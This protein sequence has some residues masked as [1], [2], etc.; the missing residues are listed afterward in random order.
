MEF[1]K[2]R[3]VPDLGSTSPISPIFDARYILA[4]YELARASEALNKRGQAIDYYRRFL[5]YWGEGDVN[6]PEIA[7]ARERLSAL[8]R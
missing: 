8:G 3:P 5:T 7:Q 6:V 1:I 4:H 2:A